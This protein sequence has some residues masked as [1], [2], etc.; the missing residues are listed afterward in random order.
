MALNYK[1]IVRDTGFAYYAGQNKVNSRK[2]FVEEFPATKLT[3]ALYKDAGFQPGSSRNVAWVDN[4]TGK[5][6]WVDGIALTEKVRN[7]ISEYGGRRA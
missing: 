6:E 5:V 2:S 4:K 7:V 3:K 1:C